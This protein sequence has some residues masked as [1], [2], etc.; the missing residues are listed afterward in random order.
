VSSLYWLARPLD[1]LFFWLFYRLRTE[2]RVHVPARG[3]FILASN[4][5]S[6]LDPPALGAAVAHRELHFMARSS[7]FR[8]WFFGWLIRRVNAHPIERGKGLDQNWDVF[9]RLLERGQGLLVFPEGTR[10]TTGEL[11][12]GKLGFGMLAYAARTPV[13]P[14]YVYGTFAAMP[15]GGRHRFQRLYV[16][17]GPPVPLDDLRAR[18]S[19]PTTWRAISERTLQSIAALRPAGKAGAR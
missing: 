7:L 9:L 16:R 12:R 8:N 15:K 6:Y 2:G 17:F 3:G 1:R 10:T 18:P 5:A 14:A 4:H 19:G 13:V 11:Q